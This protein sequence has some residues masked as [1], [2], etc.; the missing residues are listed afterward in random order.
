MKTTCLI[1]D[2]E[3]LAVQLLQKYVNDT[4]VLTLSGSCN[5]A[6]EV[7]AF[8]HQ[9]R[10]DLLFLD[11][12]MP[13]LSGLEL[14]K[15]LRDP[16]AVIITTAHRDYALQGYDFDVVDYL[17][18]PITFER[19]LAAVEKF[20]HRKTQ[21]F[22]NYPSKISIESENFIHLKSGVKTHQLNQKDIVYIESLKDFVQIHLIE[23]KK[24]I[25]KYKLGQLEYELSEDFARVHKSFIVNKN[26]VTAFTSTQL[27]LGGVVIPIGSSYKAGVEKYFLG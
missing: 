10:V 21:F 20:N 26:R 25:I 3:P 1:A 17:L 15:I 4:E 27:E 6:L 24:I 7:V 18:K 9:K 13:K 14:L 12:Q 22:K 23:G 19:F 2:D 5:N 11:I 8:L 16:P